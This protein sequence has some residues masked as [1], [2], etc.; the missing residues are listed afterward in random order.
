MTPHLRPA[1]LADLGTITRFRLQRTSW[2]AARGSDQWTRAGRGLPIETFV[3]SVAHAVRNGETWIAEV[4]GEAA[5]TITVNDRADENLWSPGELA[6]AVIV[7]YMIVDLRFAGNRIGESLLAHAATLAR[8]QHRSWVRLDAW[9]TNKDLHAYYR[10]SGFRLSRIAGPEATGPSRALFE[11]RTATWPLTHPL[12]LSTTETTRFTL[13]PTPTWSLPP[14]PFVRPH[15][16]VIPE[17]GPA[18][19]P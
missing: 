13:N 9:T 7:H 18:P 14:H 4:D 3:R 5:G 6:D 1:C 11:R 12:T 10:R 2:L 16:G 17:P 8:L 15:P 19:T